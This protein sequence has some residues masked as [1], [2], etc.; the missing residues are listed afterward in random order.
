MRLINE[1]T[2]ISSLVVRDVGRDVRRGLNEIVDLSTKGPIP[3]APEVEIVPGVQ[4]YRFRMCL[5]MPIA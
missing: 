3:R 2:I 1:S 4:I 5:P